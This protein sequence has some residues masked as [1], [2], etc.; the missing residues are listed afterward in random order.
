MRLGGRTMNTKNIV[1]IIVPLLTGC[2]GVIITHIFYKSKLE[3]ERKAGG[4][5]LIGEKIMAALIA[6]RTFERELRTIE[7]VYPDE[8][9]VDQIDT[10]RPFQ[11]IFTSKEHF[12]N[13][14]NEL[15]DVLSKHEEYLD[16][17]TVAFLLA[18]QD[19]QTKFYQNVVSEDMD[20]RG[21]GAGLYPDLMKW[22]KDFDAHLVD[23]INKNYAKVYTLRGWWWNRTLARIRKKY[24]EDSILNKTIDSVMKNSA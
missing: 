8:N 19:Y 15:L 17:K 21:I 9:G 6:V 20:I 2:I 22:Q 10:D 7:S 1:T 4:R 13:F 14:F 12:N 18:M 3:K 24:V 16:L 11:A 5:G 23:R